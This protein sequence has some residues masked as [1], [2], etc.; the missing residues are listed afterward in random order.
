MKKKSMRFE[1]KKLQIKRNT[2][3]SVYNNQNLYIITV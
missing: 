3:T 2:L 1:N